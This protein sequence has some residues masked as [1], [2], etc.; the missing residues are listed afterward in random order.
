[1][2]IAVSKKQ[3]KLL[4]ETITHWAEG[5]LIDTATRQQ[6]SETIEIRSF[7]W[8][9]LAKY[10]FWISII[11]VIISFGAIIA[12]EFIIQIIESLFSSSDIGLSIA[13]TAI[14]S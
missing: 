13:F 2:K 11:C 5:E 7:D 8:K 9:K 1:M 14:A 3:S 4:E 10:S 6:L 12:D